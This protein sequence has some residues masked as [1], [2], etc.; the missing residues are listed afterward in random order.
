MKRK[1]LQPVCIGT[2]FLGLLSI[3]GCGGGSSGSSGSSPATSSNPPT[4]HVG[5][6]VAGLLGTGLVLQNNGTA[7]L[8]VP[9]DDPNFNFPPVQ[10]GRNFNVTIL[11]QPTNPP[12]TCEVLNGSRIVT[13][14]DITDVQVQCRTSVLETFD[15]G[16]LIAGYWNSSGVFDRKIIDGQLQL[17]LA[18]SG[19]FAHDD[20]PFGS[21]DCGKVSADV[22]ITNTAFTGTGVASFRS[23]LQSCGYH[24]TTAGEAPGNRTGDVGAAIFFSGTEAFYR[25]FRCINNDCNDDDSVE[26]LTPNGGTGV[27]LGKTQND[28]PASLSIDWD[29]A[30]SPGKFTFQLNNAPPVNF[31]PVAAGA[32]INAA[33]PNKPEKYLG[34]RISLTN[35]DDK[36][37]MTATFDNVTD[38]L[39]TDNFNSGKYLNGS[40]WQKPVGRRQIESGRLVMETSQEYVGD[41]VA[42]NRLNKTN[43]VSDGELIPSAE[44]IEADIVLDPAS[45]VIDNGGNGAKVYAIMLMA[46]KPP[47]VVGMNLTN[48]FEIQAGLSEGPQGVIN[49]EIAAVGCVNYSCSAKYAIANDKQTF[50]TPVVAGQPYRLK[51]NHLGNGVFEI[52]LNNTETLSISLSNIAEF[53]STEFSAVEVNTASRGT[54]VPGEEAFIRAF[55]DNILVGN[56]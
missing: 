40:F 35:P 18:E 27:L 38:G 7:N 47:G 15:T 2:M 20:L 24:T 43:L 23:R 33:V 31:D 9:P 16:E 4:S 10:E 37:E 39:Q 44:V 6:T 53:A 17:K 42:D 46:F 55:F 54:D 41:S 3:S 34:T 5:G 26:Y 50:N 36:A 14:A 22:K 21:T 32:A 51:I 29:S 12:Q 28:T 19:E 13:A 52:T 45:Y 48:S 8:A 30:S 49:A 56:P 11:S 25:V 1:I